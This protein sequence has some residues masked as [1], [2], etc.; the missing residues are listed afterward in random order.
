MRCTNPRRSAGSAAIGTGIRHVHE[1]RVILFEPL[2]RPLVARTEGEV[3]AAVVGP[4]GE[5]LCLQCSV[6]AEVVE[7]V[8]RAD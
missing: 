8:V 7:R 5:L 4:E 3:P 6:E 1:D 2:P